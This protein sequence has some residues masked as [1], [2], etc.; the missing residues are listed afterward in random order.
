[1]GLTWRTPSP[2]AEAYISSSGYLVFSAI[3]DKL[4]DRS[5]TGV[6]NSPSSAPVVG[7][8]NSSSEEVTNDFMRPSTPP[9]RCA[10]DFL[11][12][13]PSPNTPGIRDT[14]SK[15]LLLSASIRQS[16]ENEP[17]RIQAIDE[18]SHNNVDC[19]DQEEDELCNST[20]EPDSAHTSLS[21]DEQLAHELEQSAQ[22]AGIRRSTRVRKQVSSYNLS[23]TPPT[24]TRKVIKAKAKAKA[25]TTL[26]ESEISEPFA[27][28]ITPAKADPIPFNGLPFLRSLDWELQ[29]P[30]GGSTH[31][32]YP[33]PTLDPRL[34][35]CQ[36]FVPVMDGLPDFSKVPKLTLPMGWRQA[37]WC[38]LLPVVFDPY[39]QAFKLTPIGPLPLTCEELQQGGLQDFVPGGKLHPEAGLLPEMMRLSD[40]SVD[41][42]YNWDDIDWTLPWG[43][44][45]SFGLATSS[46]AGTPS[47]D[48][49]VTSEGHQIPVSALASP[50]R[51]GRDCP[52]L[53][54]DL[55][56]AW[57]WLIGNEQQPDTDFKPLFSKRPRIGAPRSLRKLKSSIPELMM[58]AMFADR[59]DTNPVLINQ[60]PTPAGNNNDFCPYRS[61]ATPVHVDITL[62]ADTE[63]TLVELL[64]YFPQHY[65]WGHAVDR[66]SRAGFQPS[67]IR[68]MVN[69]TRA[70]EGD[71]A[72]TLRS[73]VYGVSTA[74]KRDLVKEEDPVKADDI[75]A[76]E[77]NTSTPVPEPSVTQVTANYTAEGW[78]YD[79]WNKIDYPL[80]A[81]AHGL[82]QL[83][84][85][86]D[87]GPLTSL[88]HWCRKNERYRVLLSDVPALLKEAE[89][90]P[91][92]EPAEDGCPDQEVASRHDRAMKMDYRRVKRSVDALKQAAEEEEAGPRKKRKLSEVVD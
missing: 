55:E 27:L 79:V 65:Y 52:N 88:I 37:T 44:H 38:G 2:S 17:S 19:Q 77:D 8:S 13:L 51:E 71:F 22:S 40:G 12:G 92:I 43:K 91:L 16:N 24:E 67:M 45:E 81:L 87:A 33:Y 86:P 10:T 66:L 82:Q 53:I 90:E 56:D 41:E 5:I 36:P 4:T 15:K 78:V 70:L 62:L 54:V 60:D 89:I 25:E 63:F 58:D 85:G 73:V 84:T 47:L 39:R 11:H 76:E 32:S 7:S 6:E 57:R 74:K 18:L 72:I 1:M 23:P 9:A 21:S 49:Q 83:P 30:P 42:V 20:E 34:V 75:V 28:A 26:T 68:N 69:M 31:P 35:F 59:D 80:L 3:C 29:Y 14:F 61:V 48:I 46:P 64:S 50:W